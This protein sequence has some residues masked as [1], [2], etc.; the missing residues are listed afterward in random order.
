[1]L[2]ISL[3]KHE[4]GVDYYARC[5][6]SAYIRISQGTNTSLRNEWL[7]R[8][9]RRILYIFLSQCT[10]RCGQIDALFI[11]LHIHPRYGFG[12][13]VRINLGKM[14]IITLTIFTLYLFVGLHV[15]NSNH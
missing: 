14:Q 4:I 13:V 7:R 5:E 9:V 2:L 10:Y 3:I 1:M 11:L 12:D 6:E 8:L 15:L